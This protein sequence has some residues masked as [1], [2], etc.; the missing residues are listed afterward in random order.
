MKMI[1]LSISILLLLFISQAVI[2]QFEYQTRED[3]FIK[4]PVYLYKK[5]VLKDFTQKFD[6]YEAGTKE[7]YKWDLYD[8]KGR[9][10]FEWFDKTIEGSETAIE[11]NIY[12]FNNDKLEAKANTFTIGEEDDDF[13][14]TFYQYPSQGN[15]VEELGTSYIG[16]EEVKGFTKRYNSKN[17]LV[18]EEKYLGKEGGY[19]IT[20]E[21]DENDYE[22][23]YTEYNGIGDLRTKII[24]ERDNKG[25]V[26]EKKKYNAEGQIIEKEIDKYNNA[27][28][29]T[30]K[31]TYNSDE[32]EDLRLSS[33]YLDDTLVVYIKSQ[34]SGV[35]F[36][37]YKREYDNKSRKIK[38]V[39]SVYH[40][41]E[42]NRYAV[43]EYDNED[44][45]ITTKTFED[46][47]LI[48]KTEYFNY[49]GNQ[50][51]LYT[52]ETYNVDSSINEMI[53]KTNDK[54]GNTIAYEKYKYETKFG[55]KVKIPIEKH[56]IEIAYHDGTPMLGVNMEMYE[57]KVKDSKG[58]NTK[59]DFLRFEIENAKIKPTFHFYDKP[60]TVSY[61][62]NGEKNSHI[63]SYNYSIEYYY[64]KMFFRPYFI[65]EAGNE[66]LLM[67]V[68][69]TN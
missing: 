25:N 16:G 59:K 20:H 51:L 38:E 31:V 32:S 66:V 49:V 4:G 69:F 19:K 52:Y 40:G 41:D 30:E 57:S 18:E 55:E 1:K 58:K 14:F 35:I 60:G 42:T 62:G 15:I 21:Y 3:N 34:Y 13:R 11:K 53:T 10:I 37:E 17:L 27:G 28:K 64:L 2:A 47:A 9:K 65:I 36:L 48:A 24:W 22:I 45:L 7:M 8:E 44:H 29:L 23:S 50:Y 63:V 12:Y 6:E 26:L 5:T 46:Q 67:K 39:Y 43:Y 61:G 56:V 68:P 33:N 54:Y